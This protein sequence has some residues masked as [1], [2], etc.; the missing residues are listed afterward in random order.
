MMQKWLWFWDYYFCFDFHI[1][2]VATELDFVYKQ[3]I[4]HNKKAG[5]EVAVK[6]NSEGVA[7][8]PGEEVYPFPS[9]SLPI[10]TEA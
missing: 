2:I 9:H 10:V 8:E 6:T 7:K 5:S 1:P 3:L 4:E